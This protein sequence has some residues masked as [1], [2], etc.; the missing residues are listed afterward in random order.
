L[1]PA[2][3][4]ESVAEGIAASVALYVSLLVELVEARGLEVF[5]HPVPP[6]LNETRP[7]VAA[8]AT[9]LAAALAEATAADGELARRL[10][11]LDFFDE[12]LA[13]QPEGEGVRAASG[14]AAAAEA[15]TRSAKGGAEGGRVLRGEFALDG[16]HLAPAYLPLLEREL[17]RVV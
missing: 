11:Y 16:T 6:V 15:G 3:Q 9:A 14:G 2:P 4:Y 8:F 13:T 5:V 7:V 17:R 1:R 10:H 12:L